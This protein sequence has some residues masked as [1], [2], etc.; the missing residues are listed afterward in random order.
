MRTS[1]RTAR[2]IAF[3]TLFELELRST[4]NISETVRARA[5]SFEEETQQVIDREAIGFAEEL[6]RGTLGERDNLDALISR[7][8]PIFPVNQLAGTDRVALELGLF[9]MLHGDNT[10]AGVA[11]NEAV[12]LAKTFGGDASGRFVNGVLGTIAE[13]VSH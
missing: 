9:E 10:S 5:Q 3:Q 7:V 13:E 2:T 8:A 4:S 1:R 12:E 6:V 11:I